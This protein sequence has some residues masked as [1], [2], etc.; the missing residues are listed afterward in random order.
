MLW[1]R[2]CGLD[3]LSSGVQQNSVGV[4]LWPEDPITEVEVIGECLR[5]LVGVAVF[6]ILAFFRYRLR[7]VSLSMVA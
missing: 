2:V 1:V 4:W 7:G 6:V 5:E 3:Y